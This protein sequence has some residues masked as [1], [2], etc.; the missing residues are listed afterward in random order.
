MWGSSPNWE[1]A[2][3]SPH[4]GGCRRRSA[5]A[6]A[7]SPGWRHSTGSGTMQLSRPDGGG[8]VEQLPI[9]SSLPEKLLHL[10]SS[11]EL[12]NAEGRVVAVV[13]PRFGPTLYELVGKD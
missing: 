3:G 1:A 9:D 12:V 4:R 13:H 5:T 10:T 6:L 2:D 8:T 7:S 11:T